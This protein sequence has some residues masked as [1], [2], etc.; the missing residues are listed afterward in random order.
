[1]KSGIL[2][3]NNIEICDG[4]LVEYTRYICACRSQKETTLKKIKF[5]FGGFY[6]LNPGISTIYDIESSTSDAIT[7]STIAMH[8]D[9][10]GDGYNYYL[11]KHKLTCL[12][13][14]K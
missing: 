10:H 8:I 14:I 5:E 12:K 9:D 7:L 11:P 1:M 13:V 6:L 3:I 2:D 4:N